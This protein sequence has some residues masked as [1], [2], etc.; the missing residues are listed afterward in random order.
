MRR[1]CVWCDGWLRYVA[2]KGWVHESTGTV[3]VTRKDPDGVT[4]DDHCALPRL[5]D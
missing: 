2:G 5:S 3:Y 1:H 4:R